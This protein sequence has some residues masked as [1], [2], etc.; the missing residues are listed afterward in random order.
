[1]SGVPKTV[2]LEHIA[3]VMDG[4][5]RW[6]K[7]KGLPRIA[8]HRAGV[9][10]LERLIEQAVKINLRAITV[11]AFSR[12]NWER[13]QKEI[14]RLMDLF[15]S[16]LKSKVDML[17]QNNIRLRFIGDRTRLSDEL[18]TSIGD[19]E[20]TTS[21]NLGLNLNVA[22]SYSGRW[23]IVQAC[24]SIVEDI[25]VQKLSPEEV[26]ET[27]FDKRLSLSACG[28]PDLFIRTG[29]EQ[30]I[31]N[32]LL[33]QLAYTELYFTGVLWPDFDTEQFERAIDWFASRQRRFGKI[34]EQ[35][36]Q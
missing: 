9:Q 33:W 1:M 31:S 35:L 13:P 6:A 26:D 10:T 19:S 16:S 7:K 15:I 30:R 4:N 36:E 25:N 32:Y 14:E 5:G 17:N 23:D 18:Q 28:D 22:M 11:Y 21:R 24:R 20:R 27:L 34:S 8:G 2:Q 29:G 12:E 3:I